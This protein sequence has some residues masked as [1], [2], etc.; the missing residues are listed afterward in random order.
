MKQ[1]IGESREDYLERERIAG[2]SKYERAHPR[3]KPYSPMGTRHEIYVPRGEPL[4]PEQRVERRR[5]RNRGY[6]ARANRSL[7]PEQ[8]ASKNARE[9][10]ARERWTADRRERER[11]KSQQR[12]RHRI[13]DPSAKTWSDWYV[14]NLD[15][16][17][18][19]RQ[20]YGDLPYM[21]G[22]DHSGLLQ[23]IALW[24]TLVHELNDRYSAGR[25]FCVGG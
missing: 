18:A 16:R 7:T 6:M 9:R 21:N 4:T 3:C 12:Y 25:R 11:L 5:A 1:R 24:R 17:R 23:V 14:K 8:R 22:I 19:Y 15:R 10:A 20:Q 13:T 2:R